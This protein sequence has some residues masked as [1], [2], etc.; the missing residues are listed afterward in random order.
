M[1]LVTQNSHLS[2]ILENWNFKFK[3][4]KACETLVDGIVLISLISHGEPCSECGWFSPSCKGGMAVLCDHCG[5]AF[6]MVV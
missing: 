4:M 5:W 2:G 3:T 1:N 6:S